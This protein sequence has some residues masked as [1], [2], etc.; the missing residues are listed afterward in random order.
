MVNVKRAAESLG[1]LSLMKY[2]P[3]DQNA[4]AALVEIVCGFAYDNEKIDWL[5]R[6]AL[7]IFNEWPGPRELR[8]LYCSRWAPSDGQE[9]YSTLFPADENGGGFP[10]DPALPPLP[11]ALLTPGKEESCKLLG[12]VADYVET[13]PEIRRPPPR[14]KAALSPVGS[15]FQPI[16]QSDIDREVNLLRDA[17]ARKELGVCEE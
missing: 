6:R 4:Q 13:L 2:F 9:A 5:V 7:A 14:H 16:T 3:S 12:V 1:K 8:A 11:P 17:R 10:R 15:N